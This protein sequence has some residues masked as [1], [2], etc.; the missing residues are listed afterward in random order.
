VRPLAQKRV[1]IP[2]RH[3]L[4]FLQDCDVPRC[5]V[6][7]KRQH[8]SGRRMIARLMGANGDTHFR[9]N[10]DPYAFL[11]S[12][13][14]L[15]FLRR[16]RG[17]TV[18]HRLWELKTSVRDRMCLEGRFWPQIILHIFFIPWVVNDCLVTG[19]PGKN[20]VGLD[21]YKLSQQECILTTGMYLIY[22][23]FSCT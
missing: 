15:L 22:M 6:F 10:G 7:L 3:L 13:L 19:F 1:G 14:F 5:S 18:W 11:S 23:S 20:T 12:E 9:G 8:S 16:K 4:S 17:V 21:D 2:A